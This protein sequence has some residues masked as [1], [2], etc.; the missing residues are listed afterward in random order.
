[1]PGAPDITLEYDAEAPDNTALV[2]FLMDEEKRAEDGALQEEREVALDF[3][4]GEPFGDEV[5]GR[6][7]LVTRDVAEV[8]DDTVAELL[9]IMVSGDK[10]VE[11]SHPD[12]RIA[13]EATHAVGRQFH[14]GQD[15]FR[16]LHDWIKAG[17][18]EK[19]SVAKVCVE[20]QP[21]KRREAVLSVEEMTALADQ[22]VQF[23]ASVQ[24]DDAGLQWGAAWLEE[25]PPKF[26]DYVTPNEEFGVASDAR[27]LDDGCV[28]DVFKMRRTISD[29]AE[30]G[31]DVDGLWDDG[32]VT[33]TTL[34]SV[35]DNGLNAN[36]VD[37]RTGTN[38]SVWFLEEYARFDLNGDGISEL[39]KVHRV[40]K[41][42]LNIEEVEEQPG[43]VWCPFPMP[44]RIVG[45]SLADKVMDIQ[46]TRSVAL[47]QTMDGFYFSNNP[48]TFLSESSIG[49]NT[50]D[51]LLTVVPGGIVRH[52][53]PTPPTIATPSFDIGSGITL[54]ETLAGE[55]ES[56]S[57]VTRLNQGMS[58][59]D[60]LNKTA[61][62][63][64]LMQA[65]GK[66]IA[67]LITRNFAE[68]FA[69]LMLKKYR[70]MRQFGRPYTIVIDGE[71]R[72]IDPRQW[73]DDMNIKVRVGLGTGNKDEILERLMMLLQ[74]AQAAIQSGSRTFNDTNIYNIIRA[75]IETGNLGNIRELATDPE[76]LGP[77]EEK[78][79]PE[80]A[81]AQAE[82]QIRAAEVDA[83]KQEAALNLQLKQDEAAA[84]I[85]LMREE[86]AAKL[87]LE[88]QKAAAEQ[89]LALRQQDFE[90]AMAREQMALQ[91]EQ[92][93]HKAKLD[94]ENAVSKK[95]PGGDLDK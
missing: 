22:G 51:D 87:E 37:Y 88:R 59:P 29:I 31:Y 10:V 90:M 15:G 80:M 77:P 58:N 50:I 9:D 44:G 27:D 33:L 93:E 48:R 74:I 40:G 65:A 95:R 45:Q 8:I 16:I 30:M 13:E 89:N 64:K 43:V 3:Y 56:R 39:I 92:A 24:M 79:D 47:R 53:G 32:N 46:R 61:T 7:Q 82:M 19:T 38:R 20:P 73:P 14:E 69:R 35:R 17:L 5:D 66:K 57:G 42:V 34:S 41:T 6:S 78:P 71:E 2:Q 86:A 49:D 70:L 68:A 60:T 26:I 75:L 72:R 91:R 83:K 94:A 28:Y 54:M 63:T 23:I 62:G 25:Q 36:D 67:R 81:K 12:K 84:K 52:A 76:T 11:F 1:M 55:K 21:P 85:Q 18:L 4:N